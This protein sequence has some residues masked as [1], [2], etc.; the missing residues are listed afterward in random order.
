MHIMHVW[1]IHMAA[2]DAHHSYQLRLD[3]TQLRHIA[4]LSLAENFVTEVDAIFIA[5][6]EE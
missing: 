3:L 2:L 4:K 6:V 5:I 1:H